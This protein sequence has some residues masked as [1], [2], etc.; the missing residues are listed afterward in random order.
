[1]LA[2]GALDAGASHYQPV[3]L[4]LPRHQPPFL[5]VFLH[6]TIGRLAFDGADGSRPEHMILP[7]HPDQLPVGP[8]L[9]F[10]GEVQVDI[11]G[12]F[13]VEAQEGGKGDVE[14]VLDQGR[15]A[16]G[17]EFVRQVH[18]AAVVWVIWENGMLAMGAAVV[19]RQGVDLGDA[20]QKGHKAGT[21][22]APGAHQVAVL[23]GLGHQLLGNQVHHVKAIFDDGDQLGVQPLLYQ[24]RQRVAI[25]LD[26]LL[27][28]HLADLV[29]RAGNHR[30]A[31]VVGHRFDVLAP[32]CDFV[33][34]F[35]HHFIG[36][37]LPQIG[38]FL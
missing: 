6:K 35:H 37:L 32:V 13:S 4:G 28:C 24:R 26:G 29:G 1:M 9:V 20:G 19:G 12:L 18:P 25:Q 38:K 3:F 8:G 36:P 23:Q 10:A 11:R 27:V 2:G 21:H 30:G 14:P 5:V 7:E 16:L 15:A 22:A 34:V 33:G 17:T 31:F